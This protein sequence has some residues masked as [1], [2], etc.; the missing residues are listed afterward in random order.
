M[1]VYDVNGVAESDGEVFKLLPKGI[2]N[3]EIVSAEWKEVTKEGSDYQGANYLALGIKATDEVTELSVT[4]NEIIMLP[5]PDAMDSEQIRK[6]VAKLKLLQV[7]TGTEDMG[8]AIDNDRF[9]H[10][11]LR[12]EVTQKD[13]KQYGMQNKVRDYLPL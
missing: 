2:Y 12:V 6:A 9:M 4:I 1:P 3:A 13:D 11:T 5:F 8:D 10:T 7:A